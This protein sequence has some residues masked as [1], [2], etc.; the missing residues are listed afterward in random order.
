[1]TLLLDIVDEPNWR[2]NVYLSGVPR[3]HD[4]EN[5]DFI[6]HK[7]KF[8]E[9]MQNLYK[10]FGILN[11]FC[12]YRPNGCYMLNLAIYEERMVCKMLCELA[13]AEGFGHMTDITYLGKPMDKLNN[14]FVRKIPETGIFE[15]TYFCEPD[16]ENKAFR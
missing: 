7:A 1:M 13:K 4:I 10:Q 12:P 14:D 16:K 15:G 2:T 6:K 5:Y 11:L 8:P 9:V 3:M